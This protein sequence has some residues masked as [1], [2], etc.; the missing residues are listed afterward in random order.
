MMIY[1]KVVTTTVIISDEL[2]EKIKKDLSEEF[3]SHTID[4]DFLLE[5]FDDFHFEDFHYTCG[6][7]SDKIHY[8]TES[9]IIE[10]K[11]G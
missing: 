2:E 4:K 9:K 8:N 10:K 6:I 11:V 3:E 7:P 1:R 5:R